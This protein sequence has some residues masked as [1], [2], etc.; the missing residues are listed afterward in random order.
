MPTIRPQARPSRL[1][2]A[3]LLLL[4]LIAN[5]CS[6]GETDLPFETM[7]QWSGES[8]YWDLSPGIAVA[9]DRLDVQYVAALLHPKDRPLVRTADYR[10]WFVVAVFSGCRERGGHAIEIERI[11]RQ[12]DVVRVYARFTEPERDASVPLSPVSPYHVVRIRLR[13]ARFPHYAVT[14]RLM[15]GQATVATIMHGVET[16]S[17]ELRIP[18]RPTATPSP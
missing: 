9:A 10:E 3:F 17:G 15:R 1:M 8:D 4:V 2:L 18:S 14:F 16:R 11:T 12:G 7:A 6:P 13:D 5:A